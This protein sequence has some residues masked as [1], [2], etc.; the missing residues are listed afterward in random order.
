MKK[1]E[2]GQLV[3]VYREK[4]NDW[5]AGIV[6]DEHHF[7]FLVKTYDGSTSWFL[8]KYV[9]AHPTQ[10]TCPIGSPGFF[11][12]CVRCG[13]EEHLEMTKSKTQETHINFSN[14]EY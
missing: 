4:E 1:L 8:S 13:I 12:I 10:H 9:L 14:K 2:A 11:M 5:V 3:N 6:H 7:E